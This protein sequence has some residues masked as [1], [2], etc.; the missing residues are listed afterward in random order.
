MTGTSPHESRRPD[1]RTGKEETGPLDRVPWRR[2]IVL[3]D[4][5]AGGLGAVRGRGADKP[6]ADRVAET[7]RST[8]PDLAYLNLGRHGHSAAQVRARQLARALAFRGDL[9]AVVAGGH[10]AVADPFDVDAVESELHRIV[11]PLRDTG[12]D[13]ITVG[14]YSP[15]LLAPTAPDRAGGLEDRLRLLAE[16]TGEL[17][18]RHGAFHVDVGADG[19]GRRTDV[20][21]HDVAA[22]VILRLAAHLASGRVAA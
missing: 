1:Q 14:P 15:R 4:I 16:R 13:V 3:G 5:G 8:R 11:G 10:E 7:L 22:A 2:F 18:L 20:D 21:D 9:A 19:G 6:W 17:A 12:A